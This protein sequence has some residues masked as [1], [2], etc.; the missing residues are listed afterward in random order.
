MNHHDTKKEYADIFYLPHHQSITRN[1]MSLYDRAA[2]FAAYKALSGYEDMVNEEA[3]YTDREIELSENE[4]EIINSV[5]A[6]IN[7]MIENG[8]HPIVTVS[9]FKPDPHKSGGCYETITGI[10]KCIDMF[11]TKLVLY[12]S[13][14]TADKR[15]KTLDI[16]IESIHKVVHLQDQPFYE[17]GKEN[18]D[19]P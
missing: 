2:Q 14:N 18:P 5:I 15:I 11:N 16:P 3:R 9:Y 6:G 4:I 10:V 19:T 13:N 7:T 17:S 1:H 12:G 8:D